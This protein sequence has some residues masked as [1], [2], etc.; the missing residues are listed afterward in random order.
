MRDARPA[1]ER[2]LRSASLFSEYGRLST[3]N[4]PIARVFAYFGPTR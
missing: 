1:S 4:E 2:S 3:I